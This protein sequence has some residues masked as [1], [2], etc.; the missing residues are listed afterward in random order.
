MTET[1]TCTQCLLVQEA[2]EFSWKTRG[3]RRASRCKSCRRKNY[4]ENPDVAKNRSREH[5]SQNRESV[6]ERMRLRRR[7]KPEFD[8]LKS[9]KARAAKCGIP[10][11]LSVHDIS[12][13]EVCPVL[14]IPIT[15][16]DG[17]CHAGSP[18]LDRIIPELGYVRGNVVVVSF[19][20]NT[21]KSDAS[22][23]ELR[24]VYEFYDRLKTGHTV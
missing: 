15:V 19:R 1:L 23:E 12:I 3:S 11:R 7:Q 18:S 8:L 6:L 4:H 16:G 2:S 14:G 13:P 21:I 17:Q 5:Y 10:F 24:K 22:T 20:A 9:A